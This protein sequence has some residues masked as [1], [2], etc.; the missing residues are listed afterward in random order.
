MQTGDTCGGV[1]TGRVQAG[2]NSGDE[3]KKLTLPVSEGA[4]HGSRDILV[5]S[6]C[7]VLSS[8][9]PIPSGRRRPRQCE[10]GGRWQAAPILL[11]RIVR[12]KAPALFPRGDQA[13]PR[14]GRRARDHRRGHGS[15]RRS[16]GRPRPRSRG[17]TREGVLV[18]ALCL[19]HHFRLNLKALGTTFGDR[20]LAHLRFRARQ[21]TSPPSCSATIASSWIPPIPSR[22]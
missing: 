4:H 15:A 18:L 2:G 22:R 9:P 13:L 19:H 7:I 20:R 17:R 6:A 8:R 16:S 10:T 21:G 12:Q 3:D 5:L 14:G 11:I 1:G